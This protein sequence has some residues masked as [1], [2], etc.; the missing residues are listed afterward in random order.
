[1]ELIMNIGNL[2]EILSFILVLLSMLYQYKAVKCYRASFAR[3]KT[4]KSSKKFLDCSEF[5]YFRPTDFNEILAPAVFDNAD[6]K[7]K[8]WHRAKKIRS[9][10]SQQIDLHTFLRS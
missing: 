7:S 8:S 6:F 1:M 10:Y 5:S 2:T 9:V 4:H 3:P